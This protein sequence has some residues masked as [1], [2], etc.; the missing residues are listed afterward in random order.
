MGKKKEYKKKISRTGTE[1]R[2][3]LSK[4]KGKK[5]RKYQE[6]R[7]KGGQRKKRIERGKIRAREICARV[8]A[9]KS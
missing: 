4:R 1:G 8:K 7:K 5:K 2:G 6:K 9:R 3:K